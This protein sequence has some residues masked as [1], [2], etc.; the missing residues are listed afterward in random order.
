MH[1]TDVAFS[2][3]SLWQPYHM[4]KQLHGHIFQQHLLISCVIFW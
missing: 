1:L 3:I 4:V 2:Q